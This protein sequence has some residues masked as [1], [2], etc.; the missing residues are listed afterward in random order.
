MG[1]GAAGEEEEANCEQLQSITKKIKVG[2]E[3]RGF[4]ILDTVMQK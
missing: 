1:R 3:S 2:H 4:T